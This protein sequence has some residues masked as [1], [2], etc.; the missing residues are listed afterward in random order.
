MVYLTKDRELDR[1]MFHSNWKKMHGLKSRGKAILDVY[2][3]VLMNSMNEDETHK[4]LVLLFPAQI[5]PVNFRKS[6]TD[7]RI[8]VY[9]PF[10]SLCENHLLLN[11]Y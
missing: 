9:H 11:R 4:V 8:Q 1:H 10:T 2:C 7:V 3:E 5:A 6:E